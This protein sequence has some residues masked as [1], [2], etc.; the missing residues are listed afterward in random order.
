MRETH[1]WSWLIHLNII[2]PISS[3]ICGKLPAA[4]LYSLTCLEHL[5]KLS[6]PITVAQVISALPPARSPWCA[7]VTPNLFRR[8]DICALSRENNEQCESLWGPVP[9][10]L[11][12]AHPWPICILK[13]LISVLPVT[14]RGDSPS[15]T[16][17]FSSYA[18]DGFFQPPHHQLVTRE[19]PA[20]AHFGLWNNKGLII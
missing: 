12:R 7:L 18:H 5:P 10:S 13:D 17:L 2:P 6:L 15:W 14:C 9:F 8:V 16:L 4:V 3:Q 1:S 20:S 19:L 11:I